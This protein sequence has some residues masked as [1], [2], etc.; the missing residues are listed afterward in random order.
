[1]YLET[2]ARDYE[3]VE[4]IRRYTHSIAAKNACTI[5]PC[6]AD[7]GHEAS[8]LACSETVLLCCSLHL[9]CLPI[10]YTSLYFRGLPHFLHTISLQRELLMSS[11]D[12]N[13]FLDGHICEARPVGRFGCS[14]D[15]RAVLRLPCPAKNSLV[16]LYPI[17][18]RATHAYVWNPC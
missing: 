16:I 4:G 12:Q 9:I 18:T 17:G 14:G 2:L 5:H 3:N 8:N 15:G 7:T 1:M 6:H 10:L 13:G 11:D